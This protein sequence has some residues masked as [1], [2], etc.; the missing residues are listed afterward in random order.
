MADQNGKTKLDLY[1]S[2]FLL[3]V[4]V[5][6]V[7]VCDLLLGFLVTCFLSFYMNILAFMLGVLD[8]FLN[9]T[10]K[11]SREREVEIQREGAKASHNSIGRGRT[12]SSQCE[13]LR[14]LERF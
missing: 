11:S 9:G 12:N 13:V 8:V 4:F 6:C 1:R 10:I 14:L 2:K 3:C 7:C 5:W